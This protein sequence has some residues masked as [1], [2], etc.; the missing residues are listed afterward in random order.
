MA[1]PTVGL[2]SPGVS[3]VP[4]L[5]AFDATWQWEV[6]VPDY[7]RRMIDQFNGQGA[8][9]FLMWYNLGMKR[10]VQ[11]TKGWTWERALITSTFS[12][13]ATTANFGNGATATV[14][15]TASEVDSSGNSYPIVGEVWK[16]VPTGTTGRIATKVGSTLTIVPLMTT[17]AFGVITAGDEFV[18]I[19]T[20][21]AEGSAQPEG[22]QNFW[23][24]YYWAVQHFKHTY[25]ATGSMLTNEPQ[26][27]EIAYAL[28]GTGKSVTSFWSEGTM[29]MEYYHFR[30]LAYTM[31]FGKQADNLTNIQTSTGLDYEI[32]QRGYDYPAGA[33]FDRTDLRNI[34]N[35]MS[36]RWSTNIYLALLQ[37]EQY[38][39]LNDSILSDL[40]G[41]NL[42]ATNQLIADKYFGGNLA[43]S[44]GLVS[45]FDWQSVAMDGF[46]WILK[47]NR[48]ADDPTGMGVSVTTA[49]WFD[50]L[51][52]FIPMT[53][54]EYRD[55]AGKTAL[56]S[57]IEFIYKA[58]DG[59]SRL[60]ELTLDGRAAP[61]PIGPYDLRASYLTCEAGWNFRGLT[62]FARSTSATS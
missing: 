29:N 45:T 47:R 58:M 15:I 43:K 7:S 13:N 21:W 9:L 5:S 23:L 53:S 3:G 16:H 34:G 22:K 61:T 38:Q 24:K 19:G 8:D 17:E 1:N 14:V 56:G 6:A 60:F 30:D 40:S 32:E 35:E 39:S 33:T 12:S 28:G 44:Q 36:K 52:Y 48:M 18:Q 26:W 51:N 25:S 62:Q 37:G 54:V 20:A 2:A 42:N 50:A 11:T 57:H 10:A 31:F 4:V 41:T 55:E 46:T 49:N 27:N 59:Y